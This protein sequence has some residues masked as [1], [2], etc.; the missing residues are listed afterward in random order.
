MEDLEIK[1]GLVIPGYELWFTASR[2]GGAGGQ[3]V[4]KTSSRV[5]LHWSVSTTQALSDFQRGQVVR[6][7][8]TYINSDGVMQVSA[9]SSR[10]QHRNRTEA[11][12]RLARLVRTGLER[13][14][15]R[16]A[17]RPTR[18]SQRRRLDAKKEHGEKKR[19]RKK[20][21]LPPGY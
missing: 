7:L 4:N 17:T 11:R 21:K 20:P 13:K 15:R 10:S 3:H 14:K 2:S 9:D 18:G 8:Q 12:E 6:R 19:L 5:T 16:R 1:D